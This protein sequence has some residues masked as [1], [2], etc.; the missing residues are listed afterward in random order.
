[1]RLATKVEVL[2]LTFMVKAS[3][4]VAMVIGLA[5]TKVVTTNV[6]DTKV[7]DLGPTEETSCYVEA[8]KYFS[9]NSEV[10]DGRIDYTRVSS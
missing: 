9:R 6:L 2:E 8:T 7:A 5:S 3:G 4:L 1:M 10:V